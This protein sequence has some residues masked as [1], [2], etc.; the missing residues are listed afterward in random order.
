MSYN[1]K[2]PNNFFLYLTKINNKKIN[3]F[4]FKLKYIKFLIKFTI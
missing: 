4:K 3:N 2:N 1:E